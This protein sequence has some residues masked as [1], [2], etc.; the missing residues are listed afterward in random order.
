MKDA[1]KP[2]HV[3][4]TTLVGRL[5]EGRYV[6]PDFQ[7]EFEWKPWDIRELMRS[8]FLDYYIGS[9]LLWKGKRESFDA[10]ACE[11]IYG[12]NGNAEPTHIVLDGQQRLTAMYY[13]FVAPDVA[14]PSRQNRFLYFI[15]VDR[16]MQEAYDEAFEYDWTRR[17]VNLLPDQAAQFESHMFPLSVIGEGGWELPNWVQGYERF[18]RERE[19]QARAVADDVA[20]HDASRH[21]EN[22]RSFGEH[23]KG[24]TQQYQIAYI[25][26]DR[27][28]ELD[29][30][31]DIFTQINSRGIRLD[32]FDLINA[33]LKP[34]GLQ[35]KHLWR[36]AMPRLDF[37]ET[38][39]MNVYILQVMSI[40]RQAYCSPK[41]LYYLLPGQ[42]KKVREANGSLRRE[43]LVP[44]IADFEKRWREAVDALHRAIELL[45]HPQEFG[46]ISSQ[47]L[48]YVS[49]LPAFAAL[50]AAARALPANRQLDAQRK[51]RH[52]YWAS[53]F[54]NRYSGSVESTSARDYLDAKAW[55]EDDA[56]EPSLIAEFR[57]RFRA[58]DLRRETKRGSSV[59]NG[60]FNLLVLRGARDWM[61]GNV[62]QFGDL[63][64]HHIVPKSWGKE[65]GL[66]GA[67]D[68]ILNRTPLTAD[69]NRKVIND[70]LPNEY[71]PELIAENGESAV[72]AI[73]ESHFVSPAAL[74]MLRRDPF[75]PD[76]FEAFLAE[77]QRTLQEAIEDLLIKERLDLPPQLRELDA[78][79]ET[80]EL[81]LRGMIDDVLEG[82]AAKLPLHIFQK[83]EE[84]LQAA[85]KK[86]AALDLNHYGALPGKLEYADLRELQEAVLSKASWSSF[87][88]RFGNKETLAKRF[89]QLAELRNGIRHSRTVDDVTRKEGEAAIIWFEQILDR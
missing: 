45:R 44:N 81:R 67:V 70:R 43:I 54:L 6:I 48:P 69:T 38:E 65:H 9:L 40:L 10:L 78:R 83:I 79:V 85:A 31:C 49:I 55:F 52:W 11:P 41:Y 82:N 21:A 59:Y 62:P 76:D 20:A 4:L 89:D 29:K 25:E 2:D 32:V 8:I 14:A 73:L 74:D 3:S 15:R 86:N 77:R 35:L 22:A 63:D 84:R 56:A 68:S 28:L 36:E 88:P 18:W 1:Q 19:A 58:L 34:K 80:V 53:V 47:Y 64:D 12:F 7:R 17:G 26:L 33:L 87:A 60:I 50:Q 57:A 30:V 13:A 42:E 23:L 66:G 46:G 72:R 61:T 5:R 39:R 51:I 16:F 71:L 75:G 27:E 24:I 37:V